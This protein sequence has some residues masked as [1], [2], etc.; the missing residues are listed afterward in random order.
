MLLQTSSSCVAA[1]LCL[2]PL[3]STS[4]GCTALP[5]ACLLRAKSSKQQH[6]VAR[7]AHHK[8]PKCNWPLA[9]SYGLIKALGIMPHLQAQY[10]QSSTIWDTASPERLGC[11]AVSPAAGVTSENVAAKYSIPRE[12]QDKMAASSHKRAAAATASG[13]FKDEIVPVKTLWKDPKS[14]GQLVMPCA[15]LMH[16]LRLLT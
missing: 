8:N 2:L 12:E 11:K 1:V 9:A 15:N 14:G 16:L 4:K 5:H 13:R 3:L 7:Q 6:S 10:G